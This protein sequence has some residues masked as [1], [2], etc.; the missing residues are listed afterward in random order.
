MT[1]PN[2]YSVLIE[3]SQPKNGD[4]LLRLHIVFKT[5]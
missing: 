5:S 1:N 4:Q 3:M 2:M